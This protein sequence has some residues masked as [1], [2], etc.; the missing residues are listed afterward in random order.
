MRHFRVGLFL[1][2]A[3]ATACSDQP[4]DQLTS[5]ETVSQVAGPAQSVAGLPADSIAIEGLIFQ[6]YQDLNNGNGLLNSTQVHF[7]QIAQLYTNCALTP[8]ESPCNQPAAQSQDYQLID[9]VLRRFNDGTLNSLPSYSSPSGTG[10]GAAVTDLIN[11]LLRYVG[12]DGNVCSFGTG[13]DCNAT[14]Y[15]PGSP[16]TTLTSPSGQAGVNLPE[17]T[18]TVDRPTIISVSRIP[19]PNFRLTTG[20]DQYSYR[21][22]Y[23]SSSGQGIDL[24]DPFLQ[25]VTVEVCL[26]SGQD[27]PAGALDRLVLAHDVAEPEPY[28]NI[29]LLPSGTAFLPACETL[30]SANP[31]PPT[32]LG[33]AWQSVSGTLAAILSPAP[34]NAF[35]LATGT[36]T[37]GRTKTLSP[38]GSVD[39]FGYITPNSPISNTAPEGGTVPAPSVRVVTPSQLAAAEPAGPGMVDIAVT[40]TVTAGDGCFDNPCTPSS[41]TT[42]TVNTDASGYASVPEWTIGVGSNT[43][44]AAGAITCSAP[45]AAGTV[46]DCGSIITLGGDAV[47]TFSATGMPPTQVGFNPATLTI[48]TGLQTDGYAPGEPFTVTVLVQDGEDPP[49]TVPGSDATVT[50]SVVG[51]TLV[52]PDGCTQTA[53]NGVVTFTGVYVTSTGSFTLTANSTGLTSAT[54]APDGGITSVAP[55]SSAANIAIDAG[56][57][58]TAPE[59][60]TLPIDPSVAVTDAYGNLVGGAGVSFM[61]AS[62]AGSVGA[63]TAITDTLGIASSSWTIVAGT[64]TLNAYITALGMANAVTFTATGTYVTRELLSCSPA[65]GSGDELTRAFYWTKSGSMKILKQVTLYLASNDPADEPTP[66]TIRLKVTKESYSGPVIGTSTQTVYLRGS[67]SEN[68]AT[69]FT[70]PNVSLPNGKSNVYFQFVVGSGPTG[71]KL[72]FA[73]S[74]TTCADITKTSGTSSTASI[75]KGVGITILGS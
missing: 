50:L 41:P 51:G 24:G 73:K 44:T 14:L 16:A 28:E 25:D 38:F 10:T 23:T 66:F 63:P 31:P 75:G 21:Y 56:D 70:F 65:F 72:T 46:A 11:L 15:Q 45:V 18:G 19:D 30:V 32:L 17:G 6:L 54:P 62:G 74:A 57:N 4:A 68:L 3:F 1:L 34:L 9:A 52:C 55:P 2:V 60:T 64:N 26:E 61:V 69:Q 71:V 47:L 59:A 42:L 33:R 43:V 58:Q 20:L 5:P 8:P 12:L 49:Q 13:V 53:V 35:V 48:L 37:V 22:L 39:P 27:F 40:F 67:A 36:G 7:R 29:Q